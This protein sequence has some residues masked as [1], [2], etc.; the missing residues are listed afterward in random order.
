MR[1]ADTASPRALFRRPRIAVELSAFELAMLIELLETRAT[2]AANHSEQV[3][4]ADFLFCRVAELR[5]L[6]R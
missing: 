6:G 3:D 5:E 1:S 2:I 4:F